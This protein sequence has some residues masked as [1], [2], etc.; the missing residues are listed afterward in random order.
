MHIAEGVRTFLFA[1]V[2]EVIGIERT[3]IADV[4]VSGV[5]RDRLCV[6]I[7]GSDLFGLVLLVIEREVTG[8]LLKGNVTGKVDKILN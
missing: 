2:L 1:N 3:D 7:L 4:T 8:D 5:R 6:L